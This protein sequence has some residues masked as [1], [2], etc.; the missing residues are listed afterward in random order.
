MRNLIKGKKTTW[1]D[2]QDPAE[3]DVAFLKKHFDIQD[4]VTH[5]LLEP[6]W[7][8]KIETFPSYMFLI[9][10]YPVYSKQRK[11]TRAQ[12]LDII[13]TKDTL[14]TVHYNSI[15]PLKSLFTKCSIYPELREDYMGTSTGHLLYHILDEFWKSCIVKLS[16]I[17]RKLDNIETGIF[18]GK[19]EEMLREISLAKADII[20]F[21][22]IVAPQEEILD[23]LENEGA[24]FF[25]KDLE[26]YF[27]DILDPYNQV[28]NDLGTFK[29]TIKA[30]EDT[31]NSLLTNK[32]NAIVKLLTIFSVIVIPLTLL[33]SMFGM[34]TTYLPLEENP[35]DF[36]IIT[37]IMIGGI[38][39]MISYFKY[40]HWI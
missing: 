1:I 8:T 5:E 39:I 29:E 24:Q 9:L 19:E 25:G 33:A 7:R 15:I 30:L 28:K 3:G 2:I 36:W 13:A 26:P 35:Y 21:W 38:L 16:R 6:A 23:T 14:I 31:N 20:N 32:T 12:E 18:S 17:N 22:R 11:E 37:G 10:S 34:N 40:R 4:L 27:A